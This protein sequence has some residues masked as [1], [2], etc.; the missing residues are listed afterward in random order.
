MNTTYSLSRPQ[1]TPFQPLPAL[2]PWLRYTGS[3]TEAFKKFSHNQLEIHVVQQAWELPTPEEAEYLKCREGETVFVR[4]IY[5]Q[6]LDEHWLFCRT[7]FPKKTLTGEDQQFTTLNTCPLGHIL[8]NNPRWQR[9]SFDFEEQHA[10][11]K[12][13]DKASA[14]LATTPPSLWVRR[15]HFSMSNK[16]IFVQEVFLPDLFTHPAP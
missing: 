14:T 16:I 5:M 11:D 13:F 2:H 10:G 12:L 6:G 7:L 8:F 1:A 9:S 4:E 15:S 3:T